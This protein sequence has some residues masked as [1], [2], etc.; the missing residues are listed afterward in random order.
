MTQP[1]DSDLGIDLDAWQPPSPPADLADAVI[2]RLRE[3]ASAVAEEPVASRRARWPWWTAGGA[4]AAAGVAALLHGGLARA[5]DSRGGELRATT[6]A[7]QLALGGDAHA[8]LDVGAAVR[9]Q[10]TGRRI[11]VAQQRGAVT[12]QVP[13]GDNLRI[14]AGVMGTSVEASGASLRVEVEMNGTDT[15]II[16]ATA[17]TAAAVALVTVAVASGGGGGGGEVRATSAGQTVVVPPGTEVRLVPDLPPTPVERVATAARSEP[18]EVRALRARIVALQ[19]EL[20]PMIGVPAKDPARITQLLAQ[21]TAAKAELEARTCDAAVL[22]ERGRAARQAGDWIRAYEM[23]EASYTCIPVVSVAEA[24]AVAACHAGRVL[25]ARDMLNRIPD[26]AQ[27][28]A[29]IA[30]CKQLGVT[31][32][33]LHPER[34]NVPPTLL[35]GA[36][37]AGDKQVLPD[38]ED[39]LAIQASGQNR[40]IGSFK[41]CLDVAG[42]PVEIVRL[43][44]TGY[45]RY[46]EKIHRAME[47]WRYRPY[48]VDGVAKVVCTA[49]TF[50]YSQR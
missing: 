25:S 11:A 24:A 1:E 16:G 8:T 32:L 41:M 47:T 28:A 48:L 13:A 6:T 26:V 15:R 12:W 19:T 38:D 22:A 23:F 46:D 30:A 4:A 29:T 36:R 31:E 17:V 37:I 14:D 2:A 20:D 9:W 21:I 45:P 5:P 49:V 39:K 40:V 44:S 50:V 3:P 33:A 42:V 10:R 34:L 27:R 43:K 18:V 35:E 7:Q